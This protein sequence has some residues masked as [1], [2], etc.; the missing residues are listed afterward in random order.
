LKALDK[1]DA[2]IKVIRAAKTPKEAVIELVSNRTLKF[3]ADQARAILEMKLRQLTNLDSDELVAENAALDERLAELAVLVESSDARATHCFKQL[4]EL[5]KRHGEACRCPLVS[6]P[7]QAPSGTPQVGSTRRPAP[8]RAR[9]LRY[10]NEKSVVSQ[11]KGPRGALVLES[12]DKLVVVGKSGL[13]AKVGCRHSGPVFDHF[14]PGVL[15]KRE[16]D[17]ADK[18]FLC[19]FNLDG[20]QKAVVLSGLDLCRTTSKG[21]R[22]LP[23]NAEL[24]YFGEGSYTVPWL[25]WRKKTVTHTVD[26]VKPG[27]PGSKGVKVASLGELAVYGGQ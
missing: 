3:T 19:V 18:R 26:T 25:N 2:V 16:R 10:N 4:D 21:K 9:Y 7:P 17:L 12:T 15:A 6:Q 8:T 13:V 14:T 20:Q 5:A 11:E 1:L 27:K 24:V 22:Y 23:E